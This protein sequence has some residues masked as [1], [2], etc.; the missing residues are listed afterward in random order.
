MTRPDCNGTLRRVRAV[1]PRP[2]AIAA[3]LPRPNRTW[4]MRLWW[5]MVIAWVI[6][7]GPVAYADDPI[8]VTGP[9]GLF[10][11]PDLA[12]DGERLFHEKFI[13]FSHYNIYCE[14]N[15][16]DTLLSVL[17]AM[18][19]LLMNVMLIIGASL[20]CVTGSLIA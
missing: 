14:S 13:G 5:S 16:N 4:A 18:A 3:A 15:W 6:W 17:L 20:L 7:T 8:N 2:R 1:V 9:G 19:N 12:G 11:L 10:F